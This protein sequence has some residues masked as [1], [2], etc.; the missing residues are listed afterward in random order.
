MVGY[1]RA[2]W[3]SPDRPFAIAPDAFT[4]G[5][6]SSGNLTWNTFLG[7]SGSDNGYAIAADGSGSL[8][9]A[10]TSA[11]W[12]LPVR[13]YTGSSDAFVVKLLVTLPRK[14]YLPLVAR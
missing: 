12:G 10:G 2:T 13:P 4:A 3:G 8:Y 6:D 1:S 7:G 5:L 11:T 14:L 9:V